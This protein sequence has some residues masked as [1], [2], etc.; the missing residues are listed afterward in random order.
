MLIVEGTYIN[1]AERYKF[2]INYLPNKSIQVRIVG[3]GGGGG[4]GEPVFTFTITRDQLRQFLNDYLNKSRPFGFGM[5]RR[6]LQGNWEG[7]LV[8]LMPPVSAAQGYDA[9]SALIFTG[10][11]MARANRGEL[12]VSPEIMKNFGLQSQAQIPRSVLPLLY[13]SRQFS[14]EDQLWDAL[15]DEPPNPKNGRTLLMFR[16]NKGDLQGVRF[17]IQK[18]ANVNKEDKKGRTALYYASKNGHLDVVRELISKGAQNNL[19]Y[20]KSPFFAAAKRRRND[21]VLEFIANGGVNVDEVSTGKIVSTAL[22]IAAGTNNL[23]LVRALLDRG[24]DVNGQMPYVPII[25]AV[26]RFL[27]DIIKELLDRGANI[28]ARGNF[29]FTVLHI[30]YSAR[31]LYKDKKV[32]RF[33]LQ[34]GAN[35]NL[36][37]DDLETVIMWAIRDN[38]YDIIKELVDKGADLNAISINNETA[39][40]IA[41]EYF[42]FPIEDND[43]YKK[44]YEIIIQYLI[45][46]GAKKRS[47]LPP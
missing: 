1:G 26:K 10:Q 8:G 38:D 6:D 17:L 28:D 44:K 41:I 36:V 47:E 18:G 11:Q 12:E 5:G 15:K 27:L 34:R 7:R 16:A 9:E 4:G 23:S 37:N 3:Y 24:A 42:Q 35:V 2:E 29:D 46:K 13:A 22:N 21:V 31:Y 14:V 33:L 45:E 32:F 40:D 43:E 19:D 39:L 20:K 30:A 25:T